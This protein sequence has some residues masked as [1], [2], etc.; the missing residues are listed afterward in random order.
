M[1]GPAVDRHRMSHVIHCQVSKD[2]CSVGLV[3]MLKDPCVSG[4]QGLG[5]VNDT[6]QVCHT[7]QGIAALLSLTCV[8]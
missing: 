5:F 6:V 7:S 4:C 3:W 8:F 2:L 1:D